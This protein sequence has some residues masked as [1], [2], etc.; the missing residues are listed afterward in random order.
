MLKYF[1]IWI[2][3]FLITSLSAVWIIGS[4]YLLFNNKSIFGFIGLLA[5]ATTI[6]TFL[7]WSLL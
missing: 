2:S 3:V 4:F 1:E 5:F 6:W 7:I